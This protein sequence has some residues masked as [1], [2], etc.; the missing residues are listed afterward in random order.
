[1]LISPL[2]NVGP[3]VL[4][5]R[6]QF[7]HTCELIFHLL[8][9]HLATNCR[10]FKKFLIKPCRHSNQQPTAFDVDALTATPSGQLC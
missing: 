7:I 6:A 1:M 8:D 3:A 2:P 5:V 10:V 4:F 9:S